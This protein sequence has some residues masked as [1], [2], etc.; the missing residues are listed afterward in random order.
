MEG[1][2]S[3][4]VSQLNRKGRHGFLCCQRGACDGSMRHMYH[5][6][7]GLVQ[8]A[9]LVTRQAASYLRSQLV[10]I[11]S[12]LQMPAYKKCSSGNAHA[13]LVTDACFR[14]DIQK[15]PPPGVTFALE[16]ALA[17]TRVNHMELRMGCTLFNT[18]W[19][20]RIHRTHTQSSHALPF[21]ACTHSRSHVTHTCFCTHSAGLH[22]PRS[23]APEWG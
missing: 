10:S 6:P 17:H 2:A 22:A 13:C 12:M 14:K 5:F 21:P 11:C 15:A 20:S 9:K 23:A 16:C 1:K 7:A 3:R 18:H 19:Q 4:S 8:V